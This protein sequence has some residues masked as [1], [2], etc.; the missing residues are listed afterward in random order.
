MI[1]DKRVLS[2]LLVILVFSCSV[3]ERYVIYQS[4]GQP[5]G[6]KPQYQKIPD[7]TDDRG[8]RFTGGDGS[9]M[10]NAIII[11]GAKNEIECIPAEIDYISKKHGAQDNSWKL[12]LQS[13]F[14]IN[15]K[16][17]VEYQIEDY[18][19]GIQTAY[20]FDNTSLYS[21]YMETPPGPAASK[22]PQEESRTIYQTAGEKTENSGVRYTGGDGSSMESAINISG[23]KNEEEVVQ[24]E[25]DYISKR[26][27]ERDKTWKTVQQ[28]DFRR[29]GRR[30]VEYEI[31]DFTKGIKAAYFFD[32]TSLNSLS[33]EAPSGPAAPPAPEQPQRVTQIPD[34]TAV[35]KT[36][37][38]VVR[39]TGGDG[40]TMEAAI[41]ITGA[42]NE[43]E[44]VKAEIDYITRR[45]G[46]QDKYWE[47][48]MQGNYRKNFRHF[49]E[50]NI[51]D[52]TNGGRFI[53]CFDVTDLFGK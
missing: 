52:F 5:Q 10:G 8:I 46:P 36:E 31:E 32:N 51:K 18:K 2:V 17:Y 22:Q 35:E 40:S 47:I 38:S 41:I 16:I 19:Q 25:M 27:G 53:Y 12:I 37:N 49:R 11:T 45:H 50:I 30:Y 7:A 26:H 3:P 43:K 14:R 29:N 39:Y 20:F 4:Q 48:I 13:N 15:D 24:A 21:T 6:S 28:G 44:A 42:K 9:S 34:Q 33:P 1:S 23:A